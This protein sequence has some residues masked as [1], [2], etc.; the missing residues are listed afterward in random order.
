MIFG[1]QFTIVICGS[2]C[3]ATANQLIASNGDCKWCTN[4][5][6]LQMK[7]AKY[8]PNMSHSALLTHTEYM[9]I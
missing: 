8:S 2:C 4:K 6:G 3:I 5:Y 9:L 7:P 1:H